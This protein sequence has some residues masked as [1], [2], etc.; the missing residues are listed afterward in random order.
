MA[1]RRWRIASV[2]VSPAVW[3]GWSWASLLAGLVATMAGAPLAEAGGWLGPFGLVLGVAGPAVLFIVPGLGL[4]AILARR[5]AMGMPEAVAVVMVGS[6]A[7]FMAVFWAYMW[8]PATGHA[9]AALSLLGGAALWSTNVQGPRKALLPFA[10]GAAVAVVMVSLAFSAG[11]VTRGDRTVSER[12][13]VTED[14]RIPAVL[15][16]RL[17][18]GESPRDPILLSGW[19]MSDRPPLQ[20]GA[21]AGLLPLVGNDWLGYQLAA[22]VLQAW[23]V[24][25]LVAMLVALGFGR[26]HSLVAVPLVATTGVVFVNTVFV[27]PKFLAAAIVLAGV[28][29]ARAP[30]SRQPPWLLAGSAAL[31]MLAHGGVVFALPTCAW[32]ARGTLRRLSWRSTA[33][34]A[35]IGLA[36]YV[37]WMACQRFY[38][39]PGDRLLRWHLAGDL[40]GVA[41]PFTEVLVDSYRMPLTELAKAKA[42]NV[43]ALSATPWRWGTNKAT[44]AWTDLAGRLRNG[45]MSNLLIAPATL[46]PAVLALRREPRGLP[47]VGLAAGTA[48]TSVLLEHGGSWSAAAGTSHTSY[49]A[50]IAWTAAGALGALALAPR[51]RRIVIA[52]NGA[53]FAWLWLF[54]ERGSALPDQEVFAVDASAWIAALCGCGAVAVLLRTAHAERAG[55][56]LSPPG[57]HPAPPEGRTTTALPPDGAGTP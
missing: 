22:T 52:A 16:R 37:P 51:L 12:Y 24:P 3:R 42:R 55:S 28:A 38:D 40:R 7:A 10:L 34:A 44:P 54:L 45:F 13:L 21:T 50:V 41:P 26:R 9:A 49:V 47:L 11:G 1:R 29:A 46:L 57:G 48:A 17:V 14:N 33:A 43:V 30:D 20:A 15:A 31:G 19:Q 8:S 6:G 27:W 56:W 35:A 53:C 2:L 18:A 32:L 23:W 25:A 4:T 5:R 36:L 39:P